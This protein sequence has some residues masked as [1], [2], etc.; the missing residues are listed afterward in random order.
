MTIDV[1]PV[2]PEPGKQPNDRPPAGSGEP[3]LSLR[4]INKH[5]GA[6]Q[7]LTEV[8]LDIPAG[9]V[10]ALAGDNG[11]GKSVLIK[12]IAGIHSPDNGQVL[13][14]G[15]P[16]HVRTPRDASALG[17]ETVHQDLALCDNL[18]IV[19]NMFLGRERLRRGLLNEESMETAAR[20]T[21]TSLAVTTVRSIRQPV[22]SLS[23]GQRQSVAIAKAVLWNSK[24]VIMDEPTAALGVAQTAMV[25]ALVRRLADRGLA[26]L[27]I[28]HN[29]N[30][31]FQ[32]ADRVAVLHLGTMVAIRPIAELDRQI[33]VELM[34][35]GRSS[36]L[37]EPRDT[38]AAEEGR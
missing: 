34:T 37:A 6:V 14:M 8:D 9:A 4:G 35:T 26:V 2:K 7:A 12:C 5:F 30:D 25:L 27:L 33:V 21:L 31:V 38:S 29:M 22:A 16:V 11:A 18:D 28:S 13:W 32:V 10:T 1:A 15:Q 3:L 24:L 17:I 20:E 36:R 23:G 19:Q